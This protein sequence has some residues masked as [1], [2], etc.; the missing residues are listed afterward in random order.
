MALVRYCVQ[1]ELRAVCHALRAD[2]VDE[3]KVA[4]ADFTAV[5]T[6]LNV[7]S[8]YAWARA[9]ALAEYAE[10]KDCVYV[11][12]AELRA[13]SLVFTAVPIQAIF[14]AVVLVVVPVVWANKGVVN[15][16]ANNPKETANVFFNIILFN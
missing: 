12:I 14:V 2:L 16:R 3:L 5:F 11:L 13:V 10:L 9:V 15:V 7:V 8:L 4:H 6:A 1:A